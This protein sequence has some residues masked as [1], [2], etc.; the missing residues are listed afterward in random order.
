[1]ARIKIH[2]IKC[3]LPD[4]ID[5][6]E[7]YL[8]HNGKKIWPSGAIYHR[9]DTGD[10]AEVDLVLEVGNGWVE[11]ELWDFDFLSRNDH[12]GRFRFKV[13]DEKGEFTNTMELLEKNST[14]SYVMKWE[15]L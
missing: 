9:L 8:K 10:L 14:A 6:D 2:N 11:I 13:D 12:L 4:E 7:I 5:K 1:M 3:K 15:I